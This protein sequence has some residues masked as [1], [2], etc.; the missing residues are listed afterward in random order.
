MI[1]VILFL[2]LFLIWYSVVN[3]SDFIRIIDSNVTDWLCWTMC[4][5]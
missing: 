5:V 4:D 2:I 1:L 3:I